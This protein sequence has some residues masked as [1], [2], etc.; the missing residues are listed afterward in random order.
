MDRLNLGDEVAR[1]IT[2]VE[3]PI[4]TF[5]EPFA[6]DII[7][8]RSVLML[9]NDVERQAV[10]D[11]ARRH[12]AKQ[13]RLI[14]DVRTTTLPW[15]DK[16]VTSEERRLGQTALRR[17]TKYARGAGG[18]THVHWRVEAERFGRTQEVAA[19][20][21]CVRADTPECL[22][23][24]L[25][26]HGFVVEQLYGGYDLDQPYVADSPMVVAVAQRA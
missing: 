12:A 23:A 21:F 8:I 18:A 7:L 16:G 1:S 15:A 24:V 22:T 19:E 20:T 5:A 13:A 11:A 2:L 10:L 6:A 25:R 14:V 9:L 3:G 4:E 26:Q 17:H